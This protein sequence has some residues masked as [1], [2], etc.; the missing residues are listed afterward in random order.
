M[1]PAGMDHGGQSGRSQRKRGPGWGGV[2]GEGSTR[3]GRPA[4][5]SAPEACPEGQPLM[6]G[7]GHNL[8]SQE[9]PPDYR[10][11]LPRHMTPPAG[12][13]SA[14]RVSSE[15]TAGPWVLTRPHPHQGLSLE[16]AALG[17]PILPFLSSQ[18]Q[19][20]LDGQPPFHSG[21]PLRRV[22]LSLENTRSRPPARLKQARAGSAHSPQASLR[23]AHAQRG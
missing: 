14:T 11:P 22:S 16:A 3:E 6:E 12:L 5:T 13:P 18:S 7:R 19:R 8:P 20:L 9:R 17:F 21:G 23:N 2:L 10:Q 4:L 1:V 15:A